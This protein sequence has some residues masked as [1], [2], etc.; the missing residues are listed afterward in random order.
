MK[1]IRGLM[2]LAGV[3]LVGS[4]QAADW[5]KVFSDSDATYFMDAESL[6]GQGE[7]VETWIKTEYKTPQHLNGKAFDTV[8]YKNRFFCDTR[9]I[10]SG[11]TVFTDKNNVV[12]SSKRFAEPEEVV[13]DS[14]GELFMTAACKIF[15]RRSKSSDPVR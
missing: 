7:E 13:P 10:Q 11:F 4:A 12:Y 3:V 1:A 2:V 14:Q 9:Q 5:V 8:K 6:Q 15:P